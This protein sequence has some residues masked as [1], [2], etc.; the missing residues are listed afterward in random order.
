MTRLTFSGSNQNP[1]WS[2]DGRY[3]V[4]EGAGGIFWT[5]SDGAGQPQPLTKSKGRAIPYSFTPDGA[6]LAFFTA[7]ADGA[8]L[9][10]VPVK[11]ASDGLSAGTPETFLKTSNV[12]RHPSFSP[13]GR[14]LAYSSNESGSNQIYVR[15][16]PDKGG[17]WQISNGGGG[18]YPQ[19]LRNGRELFYRNSENRLMV[20]AYTVKG[21]SFAAD[22]PRLWAQ[23]QL[24]DPGFNGI[25]YDLAQDGPRVVALMPVEAP[26]SEPSPNRLI[27]LEN[28]SDELRRRVP[29]GK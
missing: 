6:I 18:L 5:R 4:F 12:L 10:T 13:D 14:W 17:K 22:K 25:T 29:A 23:Q 21:D 1:A 26:E 16:F 15:A 7:G 24:P 8:S 2:P 9:W 19:W 11:A 3:I 28:F 20:T 27:F